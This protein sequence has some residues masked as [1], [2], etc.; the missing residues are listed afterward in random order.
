MNRWVTIRKRVNRSMHLDADAQSI[1][2]AGMLERLDP[3][4]DEV[5]QQVPQ[6]QLSIVA[7]PERSGSDSSCVET[8]RTYLSARTAGKRC[9]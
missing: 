7:Q 4:L 8:R 6:A 9:T 3:S 1:R 2:E 5:A